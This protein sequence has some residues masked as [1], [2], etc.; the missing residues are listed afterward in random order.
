MSADNSGRQRR[1]RL[2][3]A[4]VVFSLLQWTT[5]VD[6][7]AAAFDSTRT[8]PSR[9][10]VT[11]TLSGAGATPAAKITVLTGTAVTDQATLTG[12]RGRLRG[13][14]EYGVFSDSACTTLIFDATPTPNRVVHGG[15]P[16]SKAFTSNS[17]GVFYWQAV[18]T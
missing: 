15:A 14:I 11:T 9:V 7:S 2:V 18:Y 17:P 8:N 16:A 13:T 10:T 4:F 12:P 1:M 6:S 3:A 5:L